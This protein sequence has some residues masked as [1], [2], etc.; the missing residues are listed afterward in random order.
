V[1]YIRLGQ[2]EKAKSQIVKALTLDPELSLEKLSGGNFYKNP[3][4][5]ERIAEDRRQAG[6]K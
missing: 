3:K 5:W 1:V 2:E 6:L 4:T